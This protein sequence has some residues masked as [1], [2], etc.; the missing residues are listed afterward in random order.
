[1]RLQQKTR[2]GALTVGVGLAVGGVVR[3]TMTTLRETNLWGEA[4]RITGAPAVTKLGRLIKPNW[5]AQHE[6]IDDENFD[7]TCSGLGNSY[8]SARFYLTGWMS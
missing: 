4:A 3:R 2:D 1:M 7:R 5:Q 8:N 6:S